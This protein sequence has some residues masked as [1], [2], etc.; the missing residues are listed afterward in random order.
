MAEITIGV[1]PGNLVPYTKTARYL[2]GEAISKGELVCQEAAGGGYTVVLTDY[3][4]GALF[5]V[6]GIALE[7]IADGDWGD[8]C[9]GGYCGYVVTDG[10]VAAGDPLVP[11]STAG[12]CDT[13]A[14]GEEDTVFGYA[15]D[16]DSGAV[17]NAW[18]RTCG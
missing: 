8:F 16:A 10:G 4:A 1:G 2:A 9:V 18:V 17:G 15:I 6:C 11:H 13:M 7:E 12:M 3:D 5:G 14:A